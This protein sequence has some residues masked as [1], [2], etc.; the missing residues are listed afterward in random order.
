MHFYQLLR[1]CHEA[2]EDSLNRYGITAAEIF[3]GCRADQ[4]PPSIALPIVHCEA[5]FLQPVHGGDQLAVTLK[6]ARLD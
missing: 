5:D 4:A 2:W 6:P 3:P 1:W